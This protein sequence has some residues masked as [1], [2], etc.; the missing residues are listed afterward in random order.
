MEQE[1]KHWMNEP[2]VGSG[3]KTPA[4]EA[5]E[6]EQSELQDASGQGE[7]RASPEENGEI[8]RHGDHLARIATRTLPDGS[9]EGQVFVRLTREP[10]TAETYIPVGSFRTEAEARTAAEERARRALEDEEF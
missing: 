1:N 9:F 5:L 3:E 2:D 6:R 4:Q 7:R 10:A 8:L